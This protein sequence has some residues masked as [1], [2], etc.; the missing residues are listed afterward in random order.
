V[1][2]TDVK[3]A[4]VKGGDE[5]YRFVLFESLG[6]IAHGFGTRRSGGFIEPVTTLRQI[7]SAD[8]LNAAGLED[9]AC[10]G[11]ALVSNQPGRR[12]GVRTADCVPI[13]LADSETRS[14]AAIHA[15]W[16]G[17]VA[18]IVR[19]T[20]ER[21]KRD[22]GTRPESVLAAI[23]PS[24]G[25]CCYEVGPEVKAQFAD[26]SSNLSEKGR[27]TIDLVEANRRILIAA[28]VPATQ[29]YS[30][31]LCTR[32]HTEEFFSYRRDPQDPGRMV[33]F[34]TRLE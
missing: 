15:G 2:T 31:N 10:E 12:I 9:R 20:L 6:W 3:P 25:V 24:I 21:M 32:C 14:V 26:L 7:H 18:R 29:I 4:F 34:I 19:L 11:D 22:F 8:V 16:R 30:A 23:G 5:I 33:S 27:L 17:T 28:G 1:R 13:L